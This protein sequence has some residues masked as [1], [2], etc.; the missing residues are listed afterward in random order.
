M[1]KIIII[2][3]ILLALT[4]G[5]LFYIKITKSVNRF[6]ITFF[7]VGQGDAALIKFNNGEKML[8]DCGADRQI[9]SKLGRAL[10]FYDRTLDYLV[11]SHPDL[12]HYGG[13]AEALKRYNVKNI[14][15]NGEK[16]YDSYFS[17][18]EK[19]LA[20]EGARLETINIS[21]QIKIASSV[22]DFFCARRIIAGGK[23]AGRE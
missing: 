20:K 11:V 10:P 17:I 8:V 5:L 3:L 22:I 19:A 13:C 21:K 7:N 12:D 9:L 15:I 14:L 4:L 23:R 2:L 16:K 1:K 6:S 18:W